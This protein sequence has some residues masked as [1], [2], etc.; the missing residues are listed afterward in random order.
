MRAYL[1]IYAL[2]K[3]PDLCTAQEAESVAQL[4]GIGLAAEPPS[5][6]PEPEPFAQAPA[7]TGAVTQNP[8]E[9]GIKAAE[10]AQREGTEETLG[11]ERS[12][13][14]DAA[15]GEDSDHGSVPL[16]HDDVGRA[17]LGLEWGR[18]TQEP[19][20]IAFE[21]YRRVRAASPRAYDPF[22]GEFDRAR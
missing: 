11:T 15:E 16:P 20:V 7:T 19:H 13:P 18:K 14:A 5:P 2:G 8:A 3:R 22:E 12:A 9:C 10:T 17:G 6:A 1:T 21:H 4:L